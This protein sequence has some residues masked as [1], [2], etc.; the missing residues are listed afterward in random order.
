MEYPNSVAQKWLEKFQTPKIVKF[1]ILTKQNNNI[2][3]AYVAGK[4]QSTPW[5]SKRYLL[6]FCYS[7]T[8]QPL[9]KLKLST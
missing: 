7:Y 9:W 5:G 8:Y 1:K 2:Y 4:S 6:L 3:L